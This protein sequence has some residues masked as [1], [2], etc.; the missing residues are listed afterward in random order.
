MR[1]T[2]SLL[3][4]SLGVLFLCTAA[5]AQPFTVT[6]TLTCDKGASAS[7]DTNPPTTAQVHLVVVD[8]LNSNQLDCGV[9]TLS[10]GPGNRT[11]TQD[12]L[13]IAF[14]PTNYTTSVGG[15]LG[16]GFLDVTSKDATT[17]SCIVDNAIPSRNIS[18]SGSG[19]N[20]AAI[21]ASKP[22]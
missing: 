10:C 11:S 8:P 22:H 9:S 16:A 1:K 5:H 20:G 4:L 18:C 3:A 21:S 7:L 19:H 17:N 14:V 2:F 13:N 12:C 6:F 15:V